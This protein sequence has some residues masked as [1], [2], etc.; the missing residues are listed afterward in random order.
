[1]RLKIFNIFKELT[2]KNSLKQLNA[3]ERCVLLWNSDIFLNLTFH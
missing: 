2:Y 1:M 3:A